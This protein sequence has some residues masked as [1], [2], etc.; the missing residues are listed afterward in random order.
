MAHPVKHVIKARPRQIKPVTVTIPHKSNT[1]RSSPELNREATG[2]G[3]LLVDPVETREGYMFDPYDNKNDSVIGL[4]ISQDSNHAG[5]QNSISSDARQVKGTMDQIKSKNR[6]NIS[7]RQSLQEDA[8]ES[9]LSV[10]VKS[11]RIQQ[12]QQRV[13]RMVVSKSKLNEQ[14]NREKHP[15]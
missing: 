4:H 14:S 11:P 8:N 6:Y 3:M 2:K 13:K 12:Q 9:V 15:S 7:K 5:G 1:Q 10:K